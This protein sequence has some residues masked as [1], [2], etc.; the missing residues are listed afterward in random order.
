MV[1]PV[2]AWPEMPPYGEISGFA[3]R[4][5]P[6]PTLESAAAGA[7]DT[8]YVCVMDK[9]GNVF[10]ATPSDP[11]YDTPVIPGTGLC[12]SSRGSQSWAGPGHAPS[13]ARGPP[14]RLSTRRAEGG[15]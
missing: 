14:P 5:A 7:H 1:H 10:A 4:S 13:V 12:P 6:M 9:D 3:I 2:R 11:S 8:S 15:C